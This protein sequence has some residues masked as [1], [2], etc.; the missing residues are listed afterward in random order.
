MLL[1]DSSVLVIFSCTY[2]LTPLMTLLC[3]FCLLVLSFP[4]NASHECV[5]P[6][7]KSTVLLVELLFRLS[8]NNLGSMFDP[9]LLNWYFSSTCKCHLLYITLAFFLVPCGL[10]F[11]SWQ[12]RFSPSLLCLYL[13]GM[14]EAFILFLTVLYLGWIPVNFVIYNH[15]LLLIIWICCCIYFAFSVFFSF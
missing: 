6:G 15:S 4:L 1:T 10:N 13:Q 3:S 7:D 11:P 14:K 2:S 9:E 5:S 12:F 8:M